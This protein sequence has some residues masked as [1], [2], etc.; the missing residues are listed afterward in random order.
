M[1]VDEECLLICI[2]WK[3]PRRRRRQNGKLP[4]GAF[5]YHY[6]HYFFSYAH[7]SWLNRIAAPESTFY[8]L[9]FYVHPRSIM[10]ALC[11]TT[12]LWNI[13]EAAV[14]VK[15]A[16]NVTIIRDYCTLYHNY[17]DDFFGHGGPAS[18]WAGPGCWCVGL[19]G[20][21]RGTATA[22]SNT[23]RGAASGWL[24]CSSCGSWGLP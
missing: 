13:G 22:N 7:L 10:A 4:G 15:S 5:L 18:C 14:T 17:C 12:S 6:T 20:P 1:T 24:G 3:A 11:A 19:Y 21:T 9:R 2:D 23:G 16:Q 8:A